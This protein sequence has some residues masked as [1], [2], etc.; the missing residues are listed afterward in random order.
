MSSHVVLRL[1]VKISD[2][3]SLVH[4]ISENEPRAQRTSR[5]PT[6]QTAGQARHSAA[7]R[8]TSLSGPPCLHA[9]RGEQALAVL[10]MQV[11]LE[12]RDQP[13]ARLDQQL[14]RAR[15]EALLP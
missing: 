4:G 6:N 14:P 12:A 10:G 3:N 1:R 13:H 2:T 7:P 8:A 11:A 5:H 15:T 9:G